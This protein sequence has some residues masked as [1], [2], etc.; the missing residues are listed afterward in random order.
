MRAA[1]RAVEKLLCGRAAYVHMQSSSVNSKCLRVTNLCFCRGL[2][3][4]DTAAGTRI[5]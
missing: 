1:E 5:G 3:G 4:G 2:Q